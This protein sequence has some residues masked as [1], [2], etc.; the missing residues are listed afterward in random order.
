M[1]RSWLLCRCGPAAN[2]R[3]E[4]EFCRYPHMNSIPVLRVRMVEIEII[5]ALSKFQEIIGVAISTWKTKRAKKSTVVATYSIQVLGF[6][7]W[8][9]IRRWGGLSTFSL[10]TPSPLLIFQL[11]VYSHFG[12]GL[13]MLS[14]LSRGYF[15][16]VA[17]S[18]PS[19][20]LYLSASN[21]TPWTREFAGEHQMKCVSEHAR[22]SFSSGN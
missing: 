2:P 15:E 19:V 13:L 17:P 14:W 18:S 20:R 5:L 9:Y 8:E 3:G 10:S 12:Y 16:H 4:D 21:T 6:E 1:R 11:L 7:K 22:L